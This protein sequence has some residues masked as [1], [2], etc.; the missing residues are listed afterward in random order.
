MTLRQIMRAK[1]PMAVVADCEGCEESALTSD[2]SLS[3]RP[4]GPHPCVIFSE[5]DLTMTTAYEDK[6]GNLSKM[7]AQSGYQCF[8]EHGYYEHDT[9]KYTIEY[10]GSPP[11]QISTHVLCT[12]PRCISK[13][14]LCSQYANCLN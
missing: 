2:V 10:L 12:H 4:R 6:G 11:W 9:G 1:V 14:A 13:E 7:L 5:M 8:K 3:F